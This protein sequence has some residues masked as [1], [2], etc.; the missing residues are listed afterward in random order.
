MRVVGP[1]SLPTLPSGFHSSS[2]LNDTESGHRKGRKRKECWSMETTNLPSRYDERVQWQILRQE[3]IRVPM[4]PTLTGTLEGE[5]SG[6]LLDWYDPIHGWES[7][8]RVSYYPKERG[9]PQ[10]TIGLSWSKSPRSVNQRICWG[11]FSIWGL[12]P[13]NKQ[14][15]QCSGK[16][17]ELD[18]FPTLSSPV[19]RNRGCAEST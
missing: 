19:P 10:D 4:V 9:F 15:V 17:W 18:T 14:G 11:R 1:S 2:I 5:Q 3:S 7:S 12:G 6:P 16:E 8:R 13:T